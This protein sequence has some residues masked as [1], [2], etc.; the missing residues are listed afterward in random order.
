MPTGGLNGKPSARVF[1]GRVVA[2]A[3][4][5][6]SQYKEYTDTNLSKWLK[7]FGGRFSLDFDES[8]TQLV[9]TADQWKKKV[10]KVKEALRRRIPVVDP[11]WLDSSMRDDYKRLEP[12]KYEH[13]TLQKEVNAKKR[14][15]EQVR[16][17]V[18]Q[19]ENYINTN[20]YR[21]Y[22]DETNFECR[23]VLLREEGERF[24][25]ELWESNN[26]PKLYFFACRYHKKAGATGKTLRPSETPGC[27]EREMRMFCD[28]FKTKTGVLWHDRLRKARDGVV[29]AY[30]GEKNGG[31]RYEL[32][33]GGKPVGLIHGGDCDVSLLGKSLPDAA[34]ERPKKVSP[35]TPGNL[36]V[37]IAVKP[38]A[39]T[40]D[41]SDDLILTQVAD[42]VN[43]PKASATDVVPKGSYNMSGAINSAKP[44]TAVTPKQKNIASV[45]KKRCFSAKS[46][47]GNKASA[48]LRSLDDGRK[49]SSLEIKIASANKAAARKAELEA[50]KMD[51]S[52]ADPVT[53]NRPTAQSQPDA[54]TKRDGSTAVSTN[55]MNDDYLK[56]NKGLPNKSRPNSI[57][58]TNGSPTGAAQKELAVLVRPL[59]ENKLMKAKMEASV[60]GLAKPKPLDSFA[61]GNSKRKVPDDFDDSGVEIP[62][63][64]VMAGGDN[65]EIGSDSDTEM[66]G[67]DK[68]PSFFGSNHH[69][70]ATA[71]KRALNC[72]KRLAITGVERETA[73]SPIVSNE[74]DVDNGETSDDEALPVDKAAG[75]RGG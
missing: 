39:K 64:P 14:R 27:L 15:S 7:N 2:L 9:A 33:T 12:K 52:N 29:K 37:K 3:G 56:T 49:L 23:I 40:N 73:M 44:K 26:D 35:E 17:G 57:Q 28:A 1:Q 22:R 55:I 5:I 63:T 68:S 34:V 66:K 75:R 65:M 47:A 74:D 4:D 50:M 69:Q 16:K 18:K 53:P 19:G 30:A 32:P 59:D 70:R 6:T 72:D 10:P 61:S 36:P 43:G 31:F 62:A 46:M 11:D 41:D 60:A 71:R 67:A 54:P 58:A 38:P 8:V 42:F 20:L 48:G 13:A 21:I 45:R 51:K 25:I 24:I